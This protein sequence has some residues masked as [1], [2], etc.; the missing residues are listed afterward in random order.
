MIASQP[1][2]FQ[3]LRQFNPWW[4]GSS[5]PDLPTWRRSAFSDLELWIKDPPARRAILLS[6]AR[7]VGKTTILLQLVR[8][9]LSDRI[10]PGQVLYATFDHPIL[11]LIGLEKTLEAWREF[12]PPSGELEFLLLDEIQ[13][14]QGW[15]TWLKHQMDFEKRR[16]IVVT[17]SATPLQ[18]EEPESGVGR[19]R[20]VQLPTLSFME[21]L[22]IKGIETPPLPAIESLSNLFGFSTSDFNR[23]S[24]TAKPLVGHFNEHL[25]RG[26]FP[27]TALVE[28]IP[29][30]QRLLRED[31]VEKVLKR[32]MT[33]LF[34]VRRVL[35]LEKLFLYLC[36]HDGGI[37]DIAVLCRDLE[38]NKATVTRFIALLDA[39]HLIHKLPPHGY[40]KEVLRGKNKV[41]LSDPAIPG[42]V[43]LKGKSL[44]E[45]SPKL[46]VAVESAFIKHLVTRHPQESIGFSYWRG[47]G[48]EEVDIVAE[49]E[50]EVIPFEIKH[51]R[52][53]VG[54]GDLKGLESLC[55]KRN[56]PRAYVVTREMIDFGPLPKLG[57]TEVL[58]IPASLACYWL[59]R[60]E[61]VHPH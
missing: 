28:S 29:T 23:I 57:E 43:L 36:L 27:Q 33:A 59:S 30:A 10:N 11:K 31:I 2:V 22:Q 45:D 37:L 47:K 56:P 44:L 48:S 17:G 16:R 19:W 51:R 3:V 60:P 55:R 9:I 54:I 24:V 25:L 32:D 8:S 18:T 13:F 40:G 38:L 20:T 39:A 46:A 53:G 21:Y 49:V 12:A 14:C 1:E 42:S 34:G 6:G 5:I 26:G 41:Y 35:E 61:I 15:Q 52:S 50:G 4:E 7:Q 58:R